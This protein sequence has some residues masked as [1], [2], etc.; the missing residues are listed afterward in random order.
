MENKGFT[1]IELL[2]VVLIIGILSAVALPQ[3]NRA[4][5]KSRY[6]QVMTLGKAL[7]DGASV[8][9]MANGVYPSSLEDLD[10][11][12]PGTLSENKKIVSLNG[13]SCRLFMGDPAMDSVLCAG[14][15]GQYVGYRVTLGGANDG[16]SFCL[17]P[18]GDAVAA[19][20]CVSVGGKD[21][22]DNGSGL[23]HYRL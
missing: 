6:V 2:V 19:G 1:L 11:S 8:Y 5:A 23:M 18:A 9:Y 16:K 21:P 22:F 15:S 20:L 10:I 7:A 14:G 4:V 12:V 17:A 3:Y 13:Y